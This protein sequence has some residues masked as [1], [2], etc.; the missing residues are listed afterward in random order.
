ML[1]F[2]EVK[3]K[4]E[5]LEMSSYIVGNNSYKNIKLLSYLLV[6]AQRKHALEEKESNENEELPQ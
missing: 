1:N 4:K 2:V 5:E 3:T 6:K